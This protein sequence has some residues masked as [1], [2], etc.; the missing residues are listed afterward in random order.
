VARTISI[1]GVEWTPLPDLVYLYDYFGAV[2]QIASG[3]ETEMRM[4]RMLLS[5]DLFFLLYFGLGIKKANH[6]FVVR[7]CRQ[8]NEGP[9][10]QTLDLWAREHF[11]STIITVGETLQDLMNNREQ[12]TGIF[13]CVRP[14]A[15][16]FLRSIKQVL[17]K[18]QF[19][20]DMYPDVFWQDPQK[21][22]PKWSEDE[23]LIVK[24]DASRPESSIEAWGLVEG[25]PTGKHFDKLVFDD[26]VT[27]DNTTTPEMMEK[28]IWAFDMAQN[29]GVDG[30]KVRVIGTHYNHRDLFV[31]LRNRKKSDG[32]PAYKLRKKPA[33]HDGTP[34]GKPVLLSQERL[35]MLRGT[36]T[37][38]SQQLLDPT[39]Q[40]ARKLDSSRLIEIEP[41]KIP[42]RLFRF[43]PVD[44]AGDKAGLDSWAMMVLGVEPFRDQLGA[45]N[46]YILDAQ[47]SPF[48]MD[49]ALEELVQM[50]CRAGKVLQLG[51]EKVGLSTAEIHIVNALRA[52]K[53]YLS[54]KDESLKLLRPSGR[55][56]HRR[57]EAALMWPLNNG[58][59]HISRAIPFATRQRLK[60]EMDQFPYWHDDG[61]DALSYLYDMIQD[62]RFGAKPQ[63]KAKTRKRS[64][65]DIFAKKS[66]DSVLGWMTH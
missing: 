34:N 45:S 33:T 6:P 37:F 8:V 39:P 58:K 20:K 44:P 22:A 3:Q 16:A 4:Y 63:D 14:A 36:D 12:T 2:D 7:A 25:M 27:P 31:N 11:K 35:E 62:Y 15:K 42:K 56:K 46:V 64:D 49:K 21:E 50:Y 19:L 13:S 40:G 23:G 9:K 10:T 51:V 59:I 53:K 61:L 29:L 5:E 1:N 60:D 65:Y 28:T 17:E 41:D 66:P 54:E 38:F 18:N 30:G 43:L 48:D 32:T 55:E 24:R 26:V 52:K 47:I 57:I